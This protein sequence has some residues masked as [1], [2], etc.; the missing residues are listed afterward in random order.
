MLNHG[1]GLTAEASFADEAQAAVSTAEPQALPPLWDATFEQWL[2]NINKPTHTIMSFHESVWDRDDV[3]PSVV[4]YSGM[5][6]LSKGSVVRRHGKYVICAVAMDCDE[7][8]CETHR[9][10]NP[11]IPRNRA[12]QGWE[13][14]AHSM[15]DDC[16]HSMNDLPHAVRFLHCR[17]RDERC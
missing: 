6:G 7:L 10:N 3:L 15:N 16:A 12:R 14:Q 17:H 1:A 4:F 13:S 8:A 9:L 5:G 11:S 2:S